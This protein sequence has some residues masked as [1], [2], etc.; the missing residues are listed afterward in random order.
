MLSRGPLFPES[1]LSGRLPRVE[2]FLLV[3]LLALGRDE[4]LARRKTA[5]CVVGAL[6]RI[7]VFLHDVIASL[8]DW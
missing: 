8:Y 3:H 5:P 7:S 4:M 6:T 2:L 1:S